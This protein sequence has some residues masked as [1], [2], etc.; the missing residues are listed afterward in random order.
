LRAPVYDWAGAAG[1]PS[2][3]SG[4]TTAATVFA[5]CCVW[6]LSPRVRR[7]GGRRGMRALWLGAAGYALVVGWTRVWLGVHWSSD[8]LG[9]WLYGTAWCS[10]AAAVLLLTRRRSLRG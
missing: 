4:H 8:V 5:L 9:G 10:L 1:G 6:A 2:F 7:D 3:P